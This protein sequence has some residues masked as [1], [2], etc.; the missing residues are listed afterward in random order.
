V[1][2]VSV[3][4][5]KE[6]ILVHFVPSPLAISGE[7]NANKGENPRTITYSQTNGGFVPS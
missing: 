1:K 4:M 3:E 5:P 2:V 7:S 6:N